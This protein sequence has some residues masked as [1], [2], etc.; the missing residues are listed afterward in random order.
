MK[1]KIYLFA[2]QRK[3]I[4]IKM[5]CSTVLGIILRCDFMKKS[6]TVLASLFILSGIVITLENY[7]IIHGISIHWPALVCLLGAGF[8]AL[9]FWGSRED[10]ALLW[11]GTFFSSLGL[12]FYYLNFTSWSLMAHEWPLFLLITALSFMTITILTKS[13]LYLY[14]SLL[15]LALFCSLY[16]VFN[17]SLKLWPVSMIIFGLCLLGINL[18]GY[19]SPT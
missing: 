4:F 15:F 8:I 11:I 1:Q 17:V 19:K 3:G 16:L 12:V 9:F 5:P 7:H 10:A 2:R 13:K 6:L 14:F 18:A